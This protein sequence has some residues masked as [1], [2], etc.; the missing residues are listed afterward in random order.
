MGQ[1]RQ[2]PL[3]VSFSIVDEQN[4]KNFCREGYLAIKYPINNLQEAYKICRQHQRTVICLWQKKAGRLG[5]ANYKAVIEPRTTINI[6]LIEVTLVPGDKH[7]QMVEG[8]VSTIVPTSFTN[9]GINY[10]HHGTTMV[11]Y[12]TN[13]DQLTQ[14]LDQKNRSPK[15]SYRSKS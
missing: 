4:L 2:S 9:K 6:P 13:Y 15:R 10:G 11:E 3:C 5:T 14:K 1:Q 7:P 8:T 12:I